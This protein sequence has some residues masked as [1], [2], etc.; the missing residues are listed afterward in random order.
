M[1][2]LKGYE[3]RAVDVD[4]VLSDAEDKDVQAEGSNTQTAGTEKRKRDEAMGPTN[5]YGPIME[6]VPYRYQ[7]VE[8]DTEAE[9]ELESTDAQAGDDELPSVSLDR[10]SPPRSQIGKEALGQWIAWLD[11]VQMDQISLFYLA[12]RWATWMLTLDQGYALRET[13]IFE[14][15]KRECPASKG[16]TKV[17]TLEG[18]LKLIVSLWEGKVQPAD[19]EGMLCLQ[20][21]RWM[22][23]R[24]RVHLLRMKYPQG[25]PNRQHQGAD[26]QTQKLYTIYD[27]STKN[28]AKHF[29]NV[30]QMDEDGSINDWICQALKCDTQSSTDGLD[31]RWAMREKFFPE[32]PL[33]EVF[34]RVKQEDMAAWV[35]IM[36]SKRLPGVR[37]THM[38]LD[39]RGR[40][41]SRFVYVRHMLTL[42]PLFCRS[43]TCTL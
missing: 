13:D 2:V 32:G 6:D 7:E 21:I 36:M 30:S 26:D 9:T 40:P 19:V 23:H 18:L 29:G 25:I 11:E 20:G 8:E 10:D 3:W 41:P 1:Q 31:I 42:Y 27:Q 15:Y 33:R 43:H 39:Y 28:S 35:R 22:T 16:Q 17:M 34:G 12:R 38:S 5:S 37:D 14:C 24:E 4:L